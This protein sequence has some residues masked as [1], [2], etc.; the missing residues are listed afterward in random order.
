MLKKKTKFILILLA[1]FLIVSTVSFATDEGIM[2]I[3]ET[4]EE[5]T[6]EP[7]DNETPNETQTAEQ[8]EIHNGD[9]YLFDNDIVMDQLVDG[10]VFIF[11]NNVK[12]TGKVNGSLYVCANNLT[13]DKDSYI[14]QSIYACANTIKFDGI[15]YYDLYASCRQLDMSSDSFVQRDLRV[16]ADTLNFSSGVGRNAFVYVNTFNFMKESDAIVYGDLTYTASRELELS[17]ELVQGNISYKPDMENE[18]NSVSEVILDKAIELCS[19]LLYVAIVFVLAILLAPKFMEKA[20]TY[21]TPATSAKSFGIGI[22]ATIMAVV[23]SLVLLFSVI[24]IPV[25]FAIIAL[26]VL[27][28][29]IAT[30]VTSIC[31]TYRLKEKFAYSKDCLTYLTLAGVVIVIWVLKL[32]PYVGGVV[33]FVI[34][35]IGLGIIVSYL[36]QKNKS[37]KEVKEAV[38]KETPKK[39]TVKKEKK[40]KAP[41]KEDKK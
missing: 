5:K 22:L 33:S 34:K 32:I 2:P 14:L 20:S 41:K 1:A 12:V 35:M 26:L 27:L 30:A 38:K 40:E 19:S 39:E 25:S 24:G 21:I 18:Q 23:I 15:A 36:L 6:I 37:N 10:N 28:L 7:R 11:G 3:S 8:S 17:Q 9:L 31:I 16:V 4:A 29:S 13:F